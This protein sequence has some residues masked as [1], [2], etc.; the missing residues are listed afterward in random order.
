MPSLAADRHR[1]L[2]KS[3]GSSVANL[4]QLGVYVTDIEQRP[5][6]NHI[7]QQRA[8][9]APPA[10]AVVPMPLLHYGFLVAVKA[11]GVVRLLQNSSCLR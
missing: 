4:T 10:R 8:G 3:A 5:A 2:L 11:V 1:S 9:A 6:F 7:Y